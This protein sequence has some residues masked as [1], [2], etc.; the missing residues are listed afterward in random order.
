MPRWAAKVDTTSKAVIQRFRDYGADWLDTSR[1]PGIDGFALF[2]G[3]VIA[4]EIKTRRTKNAKVQLTK[5][6][7][8]MIDRGWPIKV[9]CGPDDVPSALGFVVK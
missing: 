1:T 3:K 4:V 8:D 7:C 6:Q 2:R 5:R 9:V